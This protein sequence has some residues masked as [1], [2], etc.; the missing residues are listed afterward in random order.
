MSKTIRTI[1][2][3]KSDILLATKFKCLNWLADLEAELREAEARGK[4]MRNK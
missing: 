3:I 1:D 2:E 4:E